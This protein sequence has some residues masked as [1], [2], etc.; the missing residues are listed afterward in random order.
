LR[1]PDRRAARKKLLT[2]EGV[3]SVEPAGDA[4]HLFLTPG[5]TSPERL[6]QLLG[7]GEFRPIAPSLED[8]FIA[9]IRKESAA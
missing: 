5:A 9:L 3:A 7:G 2:A 1:V 4:L 8:V 6:R